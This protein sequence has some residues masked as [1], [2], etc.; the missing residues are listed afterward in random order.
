MEGEEERRG[1]IV[2][3]RRSNGR[4][5]GGVNNMADEHVTFPYMALDTSA[6]ICHSQ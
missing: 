6:Y 3:D 5:E 1:D 4:W 2:P